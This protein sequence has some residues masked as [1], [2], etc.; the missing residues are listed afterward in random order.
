MPFLPPNQQRESTEGYFVC[1]F[2]FDENANLCRYTTAFQIVIMLA[3]FGAMAAVQR[4]TSTICMLHHLY[5][6]V[7]FLSQTRL[8]NCPQFLP[9][10]VPE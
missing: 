1:I 10:F 6:T 8:S 2:I 4:F 5:F 7:H 9:L 3:L